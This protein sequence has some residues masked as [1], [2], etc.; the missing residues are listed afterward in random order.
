MRSA[1]AVLIFPLA[2][3]LILVLFLPGDVLNGVEQRLSA[4]DS[5]LGQ[6][7]ERVEVYAREGRRVT[8]FFSDGTYVRLNVINVKSGE[9]ARK[10]NK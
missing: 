9:W 8:L 2:T 6:G 4:L 3:L 1:S 7:T 10:E 5:K